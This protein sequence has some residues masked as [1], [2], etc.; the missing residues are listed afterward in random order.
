MIRK[1]RLETL[2]LSPT[3]YKILDNNINQ[4]GYWLPKVAGISSFKIPDTKIIKVPLSLLQLG[5]VFEYSEL[6][7]TTFK[8]I[9]EY[10]K[11]V[12]ELDLK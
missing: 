6:T 12:F 5:R 7:P 2:D 1:S 4:I 11:R 9:N 8:I 3:L 10:C